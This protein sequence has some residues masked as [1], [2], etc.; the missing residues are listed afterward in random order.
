MRSQKSVIIVG[1]GPAALIAADVLSSAGHPVS[2]FEKRKSPGRKLLVAGSSGLNITHQMP[3]SEFSRQYFSNEHGFDPRWEKWLSRFSPKSWIEWIESLEIGT[4]L[5]TSRRYFIDDK[6]AASFLRA[7]TQK[8]KEQGVAFNFEQEAL[9]F[10]IESSGVTLTT[11]NGSFASD[12]LLFALGGGSWEPQETPVRW[13]K[14]FQSKGIGFTPFSPANVGYQVEWPEAFL[15][16]AEGLPLKNLIL[17]SSKGSKKG[18]LTITRYGLEGTPI[19][20]LGE[21]G[22]IHIDLKPDL[23]AEQIFQRLSDTRENLSPMRRTQ[24]LLNLSPAALALVYHLSPVKVRNDLPALIS[25]IKAFPISL[26]QPQPLQ[27]AISAHGG[28]WMSELN[29]ELMFLNFPGV[30]AAGEMLDWSAPTGGFLIQGC[31]TQGYCAARGIL[32][33]FRTI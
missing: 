24:K 3:L 31:V 7:W 33:Q 23:S 15:K 18:E 5:G 13:P 16:E 28:I 6:K 22:T 30:Y 29:D 21:V 27:E 10:H 17:T 1:T 12:A 14:F 9:D 2:L 20:T 11:S 25:Q 4:F 19:Y 32:A 26:I 8:L